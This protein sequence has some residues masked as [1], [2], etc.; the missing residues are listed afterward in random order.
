MSEQKD[1]ANI[2][3]RLGGYS[4]YCL[5]IEEEVSAIEGLEEMISEKQHPSEVYDFVIKKLGLKTKDDISI[6]EGQVDQLWNEFWYDYN[7]QAMYEGEDY[8][9][10]D[11]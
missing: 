8:E 6:A 11:Y 3:R 1:V 5:G 2:K 10:D 9:H 4:D 7:Q